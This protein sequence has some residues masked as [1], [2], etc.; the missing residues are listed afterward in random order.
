MGTRLDKTEIQLKS[1]KNAK[2]NA[3]HEEQ[4][5]ERIKSLE[6]ALVAYKKKN[7][8]PMDGKD[9]LTCH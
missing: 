8:E 9:W 5:E 7:K 2:L 3:E 6:K 1:V 4:R